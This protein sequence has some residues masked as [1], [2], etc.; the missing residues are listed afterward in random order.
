MYFDVSP[1][2]K[3]SDL[4]GMDYQLDLLTRYL[5]DKSVRLIVIKGLR[6]TGKTSL[7]N[8]ALNEINMKNVKID[9]R[10][11]PFYDK[12]EFLI[13]LIKKIRERM[14]SFLDKII[15]NIAGVKLGYGKFSF[16]LFFSKEENINSFFE[17]LNSWLTKK[18]QNLILAFDEAQLLKGIKF[19]YFLASIFDNYKS[20]KIVLTGSEVGVLD[21]LLGKADYNAPL[22]GRAYLEIELKKLKEEDV[23]KFLELGFKQINKKI[24]FEEVREVVENLDGII[25][26]VTYYGWFRYKGLSHRKALEKVKEE[27]SVLTKKE[28]EN[29]LGERKAK[30]RYL[31]LLKYLKK[32]YNSWSSLKQAFKKDGLRI[33]DSQLNLYLKEL[34]DFGFIEKIND[35]YFVTDPLLSI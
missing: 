22:F 2:T 9:V 17:N 3:R 29:F 18:R 11:S 5:V 32:G 23:T 30:A 10:E 19:D 8:V 26:W 14:G 7:L 25:G 16:E 15:E 27:G 28:L 20:I 35:K 4:F 31:K 34:I 12:K 33:S 21:K 6:R 1:K 13:F 24:E